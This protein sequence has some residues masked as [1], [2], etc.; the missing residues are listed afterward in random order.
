MAKL[1]LQKGSLMIA[2]PP[3]VAK[4]LEVSKGDKLDYE[5]NKKTGRVELIKVKEKKNNV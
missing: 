5:F 4:Y 2:V 3:L 1:Q